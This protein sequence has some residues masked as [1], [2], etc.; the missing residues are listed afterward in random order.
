MLE[1]QLTQTTLLRGV[2]ELGQTRLG[3]G[4]AQRDE[5]V[6]QVGLLFEDRLKLLAVS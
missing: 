4:H 2:G 3:L 5:L 1:R 6:V